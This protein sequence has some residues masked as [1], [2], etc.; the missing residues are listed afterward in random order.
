M[1][2]VNMNSDTMQQQPEQQRVESITMA[3]SDVSASSGQSEQV[4]SDDLPESVI[5]F[6]NSDNKCSNKTGA[7]V[8]SISNGHGNISKSWYARC[9]RWRSQSCDRR[10]KN[11]MMRYSWN[12]M[13]GRLV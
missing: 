9:N 11:S 4:T 7:S 8:T 1:I 6:E 5:H 13:N 3:Q 10:Q 12:T 2:N